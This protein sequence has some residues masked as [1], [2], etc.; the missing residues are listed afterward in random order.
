M[1]LVRETGELMTGRRSASEVQTKA[2]INGH[3][4]AGTQV[5]VD[6]D[7][8]QGS[9]KSRN[10]AFETD[11][12]TPPVTRKRSDKRPRS[13]HH[14][15][16]SVEEPNAAM[17]ND[18][19]GDSV[20]QRAA[21]I[22]ARLEGIRSAARAEGGDEKS[23]T[24][25]EE[26]GRWRSSRK[27]NARWIGG[28]ALVASSGALVAADL[29]VIR[30]FKSAPPVVKLDSPAPKMPLV[31]DLAP[32]LEVHLTGL[33]PGFYVASAVNVAQGSTEHSV[34][35]TAVISHEPFSITGPAATLGLGYRLKLGDWNIGA[36]IDYSLTS[37][38]G[39]TPGSASNPCSASM[40]KF[41]GDC[42]SQVR[43]LTT[44]RIV[45]GRNL[46]FAMLYVT[47]GVAWGTV[48]GERAYAKATS[49]HR[50][51]IVG[52]GLEMPLTVQLSIKAEYL[53]AHLGTRA[54]Y[55]DLCGCRSYRISANANIFRLGLNYSF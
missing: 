37:I 52:M 51:W 34:Q 45:I 55:D 20:A 28:L 42:T 54:S 12:R 22:R 10:A 15:E 43:N 17:P 3:K 19:Y 4:A 25:T 44:A 21:Q 50:G 48:V 49:A 2:N 30:I 8:A 33:Q 46:S 18:Q 6:S 23:P 16:M 40:I 27:V 29:P 5:S 41:H 9:Q 11:L 35:R 7:T 26:E 32:P 1:A 14:T 38:R 53:Y 31:T 47:G 24:V 13:S 39:V 36:E